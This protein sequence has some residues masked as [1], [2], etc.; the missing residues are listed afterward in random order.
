MNN[1]LTS[2]V[3]FFI[4]LLSLFQTSFVQAN[5]TS[6]LP[7]II[8]SNSTQTY[9]VSTQ[10]V[11]KADGFQQGIDTY[12]LI[13][14][15]GG[16]RPIEAPDLYDI[17]HPGTPH[18]YEATDDIVG[19]HF[20][21][22]LHKNKD[23]DRDKLSKSDRQRNEIKAYGGSE[24][25]LKAYENEILAYSWK[26]KLDDGITFSKNFGHIFQLKAVDDGPG[27][28][29]LTLTGR[30]KGGEWLQVLH[31]MDKLTLLK[32]VPLIPLKGKWLQVS[33]FVNYNNEG[34]LELL[35]TDLTNNDTNTNTVLHLSINNIDMWRGKKEK[36][37]VRPKWGLY[38]SLRSK[39][40]LRDDEE[41]VFF[42]DFI[43]QKLK[44]LPSQ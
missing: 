15:W 11:L 21:F 10:R 5:S 30:N 20:I 26:F 19:N 28:P 41:K 40:M 6:V 17:N 42:A 22:T 1:L 33:C 29:V 4:V 12:Q 31:T 2:P 18:I 32:Q 23:M 44:A 8:P 24:K 25:A 14:N 39:D 3:L 27:Y 43:V 7:I 35:I 38:R 36:D 9:E 34:Q 13:R 37:F 16:K